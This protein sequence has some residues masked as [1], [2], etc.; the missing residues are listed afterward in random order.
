MYIYIIYI[1]IYIYDSQ[2]V[3]T[4][5]RFKSFYPE[6]FADNQIVKIIKNNIFR[7]FDILSFTR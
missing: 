6:Y 4:I 5:N 7:R 2:I 1:Y 3:H